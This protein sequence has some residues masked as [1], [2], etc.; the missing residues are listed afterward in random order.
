MRRL[1][2][3]AY[4]FPPVGGV[5]IERTLKHVTYL[6]EH[7]WQ[8]IVVTVAGSG[9]RI[10]DPSIEAR[11][12]ADVE[13]HR[14]GTME[15]AHLRRA[16]ARLVGRRGTTASRSPANGPAAGPATAVGRLR[17]MANRVWGNVVP[18]VFFPDDQ[19]V[20]ARRAERLGRRIHASEPV[21]AIYSSS[22]P[23][24]GHL[25]AERIARRARLPWIADFRD[26]WIGNS[27]A[28]PL[29]PLHRGIQQHLER[30]IVHRADRV[31]VATA[32]MQAQLMERYPARA[33]RIVHVPNGYDPQDL[34]VPAAERTDDDTFRLTYAG[35]LYGIAELTVFLD[36]VALLI[37]RRPELRDRLRVDF[38]G[39]FSE[40]TRAI[41]E[42]RLPALAPVVRQVGFVPRD[43]AI[44][45]QRA[46]DAGLV[47][48]SGTGNRG[49]VATS[50]IYEYLG[51]DLPVLAI[52]PPGE[53]R[54]I[55]AGL[56]W[57]VV[58]DPTP[59]GV[60]SGL[61]RI[62]ELPPPGRAADP[63]RRYERRT[64]SAQLARLLDEVID[65]PE[66]GAQ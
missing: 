49:V 11:V 42:R 17:T 29:N 20:W 48:I 18:L 8:P 26:P 2:V 46:S 24:S 30:R 4:F 1:L 43:R 62:M 21:D 33:D 28:R 27:F 16:L 7:G 34:Q 25:A 6:P 61:E 39:W 14:A 9:Y 50:K 41:A 3:I 45:L 53:V 23:I 54:Q 5:G 12:P 38:V 51:L 36:G 32:G 10:V 22:P 65:A 58:A 19:V 31:I 55:L 57:G 40:E 13:V 60:A 59:E 52:V 37:T 63:E 47:I 35:S 15:P 66:P 44:A 64:L 56:D